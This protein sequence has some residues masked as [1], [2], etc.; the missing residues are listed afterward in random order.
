MMRKVYTTEVRNLAMANAAETDIEP[1]LEHETQGPWWDLLDDLNLTLAVSREYEHFIMLIGANGGRPSVSAME[2]PHPSGLF[3]DQA[4]GELVV[5]STR[6]PNQVFWF[7]PLVEADYASDVIPADFERPDGTLFLPYRSLLLPG[8]LYIHDLAMI[9][10]DLYAT[11]TGHN[12]LARLNPEGGW[13]R[14]W[15]PKILDGMGRAAFDQ[16]YLQLNSIGLGDSPQSSY[17][18]AFAAATGGPKPWKQGYGPNGRGVVFFGRTRDVLVGGLT[19]PH[20]AKL[21]DGTLW[22]CNSGYGEVGTI[23]LNEQAARFQPLTRLNG[24][25]RGMAFAGNHAFIGLSR[26]L[27]FYEPYAPGLDPKASCCGIAAVDTRS[28]AVTA[29]L[30]WPA[31]QQI[32]DIQV[33]PRVRRA[34]LPRKP[35]HEQG[36]NALLR[37]LG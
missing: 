7:R 12:F 18:T 33:M 29:S 20:S 25:T 34:L 37:Y 19:C 5:S 26:V 24:F 10:T 2:L 9:G 13:C 3:Y 27:D 4:T 16:N 22:L 15:W 23:D 6:T 32:Y 14:I 31:G 28:G 1:L 35:A 8:T 11:V 36:I 30:T 17:Y 21:R